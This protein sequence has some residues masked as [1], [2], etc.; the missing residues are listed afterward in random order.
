MA[1][2]PDQ[3][4]KLNAKL[5]ANHIRRR[6]HLGRELPYLEGWHV[7]N[8]ANRIFGFDSWDRETLAADCVWKRSDGRLHVCSYIAHVR[9]RVR[10][11]ETVIIRDGRGCGHGQSASAG[12][13]HESAVKAAETDATKRALATFGHPFGLA[14]YDRLQR[15]VRAARTR[16]RQ[17]KK[18]SFPLFDATGTMT[19]V[20]NA[21][22]AFYSA[23]MDALAMASTP[24]DVHA[25]RERNA[26][27]LEDLQQTFPKAEA[28]GGKPL[29]ETVMALVTERIH[30]LSERTA[31]SMAVAGLPE[32]PQSG[33]PGV[34]A[35]ALPSLERPRPTRDPDH[36]RYVAS[37][38]CLIC[39][40]TPSQAHHVKP[41]EPRAM[42]R[43][44][45]DRWVVPL[46]ATHHRSLHDAGDES[47]WW[48]TRGVDP[49]A[50]AEALWKGSEPG[51]P[52]GT[53]NTK[54]PRGS[55]N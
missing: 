53:T 12:E 9:I 25:L 33:D 50:A 32:G 23:L 8:E 54:E 49:L 20:F 40:R 28:T 41:A 14:L 44:V 11:E 18:S 1:F 13:A 26:A 52:V 31:E 17:D 36:R 37:L 27:T 2:S 43:K 10:T 30:A 22:Q 3:L 19:A 48:H 4:R 45:S 21:P 55:S 51:H 6:H 38:P 35:V 39:G 42:G 16:E 46:C 34:T 5:D 15:H 29:V 7:V 24:A 47:R